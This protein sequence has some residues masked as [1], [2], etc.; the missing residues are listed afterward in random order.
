MREEHAQ[1]A[2]WGRLPRLRRLRLGV[3][4]IAISGARGFIGAAL[5][6]AL[7][8]RG[9]RVLPLQ[10][11]SSERSPSQQPGI[12]WDP[13]AGQIEAAGLEGISALVHLAGEAIADRRWSEA[14]KARIKESRTRGTALLARTIVGLRSKPEVFI[15][16]SA[17]GIYGD[18]GEAPI[19]ETAPP[20]D[21]F[22]S[23][24]CRAW[25]EAAK[26]AEEAGIRV[27]HVRFG[28]V[29]HPDGGVLGKLLTPFKLGLGGKLGSGQQYMSWVARSDVVRALLHVLDHKQLRGAF[30]ITAPNP[31]RNAE[32]TASLGRVLQRPTVF[33]VPGF[34]ARALFGEMADGA[35]LSGARVLPARLLESGFS[36]E[37]PELEPYLRQVLG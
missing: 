35:L 34:A 36:F 24:V 31:T 15:S 32:L 29:L 10:R 11:P 27:V 25:E 22:L 20:G 1:Y 28:L 3:A 14:Q 2:G 37:Q 23:E 19:D 26:P 4:T 7:T 17:I 18:R 13:E 16:A 21:D 33:A 5:S 6:Q 12:A 8:Q 9:D 30:N